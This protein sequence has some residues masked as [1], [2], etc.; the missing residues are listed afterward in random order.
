MKQEWRSEEIHAVI[1]IEFICGAKG[2]RYVG[3]RVALVNNL[4]GFERVGL[5]K[6]TS[7]SCVSSTGC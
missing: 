2:L 6:I 5:S 7:S 4:D 3:G 1:P